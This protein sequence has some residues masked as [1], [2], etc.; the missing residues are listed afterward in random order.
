MT[1]SEQ[2]S[3]DMKNAMRAK[4]EAA[5]STLRLLRSA[6]KNK[7][8]DLGHDLSDSEVQDVVRVQVKQLKDALLTY[9]AGDHAD[10]VDS[11]KNELQIL[12]AYLPAE[13]P[14]DELAAIVKQA[15]VDSGAT[16]KADMGK[17]MGFV[18]KVVAGRADGTRVKALV[19]SF[20]TAF[21]FVFVTSLLAAHPAHASIDLVSVATGTGNDLFGPYMQYLPTA[22]RCVRVLFLW[23]GLFSVNEI[24]HGGF[25]MT[26]NASR[27]DEHH[28]AEHMMM[29]GFIGTFVVVCL[30]FVTTMMIQR[31]S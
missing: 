5:L 9:E 4:A 27:D 22:L 30:F 20:L 31:L 16:Q 17:A 10:M 28:H 14:E 6:L 1:L 7:Q 15:L 25:H 11:I 19:E 8:I 23:A 12:A 24:I 26:V 13:M 2:I 21:A 29:G 18:M 3:E